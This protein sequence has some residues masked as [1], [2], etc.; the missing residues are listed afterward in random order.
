M[1]EVE[2]YR[3]SSA[4]G[5]LLTR[6]LEHDFDAKHYR[7]DPGDVNA[8]VREGLK[9]LEGERARWEKETREEQQK[10]WEEKRRVEE[11]QRRRG[12]F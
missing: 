3:A 12:G 10:E 9:V 8:E 1:I 2:Y 5:H 7:I 4:T 6:V 11:M